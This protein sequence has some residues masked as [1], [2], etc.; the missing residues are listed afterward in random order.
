MIMMILVITSDEGYSHYHYQHCNLTVMIS[1]ILI[2]IVIIIATIIRMLF[3]ITSSCATYNYTTSTGSCNGHSNSIVYI[4]VIINIIIS[5]P[6]TILS[7]YFKKAKRNTLDIYFFKLLT[8]SDC[9]LCL[10]VW[11]IYQCFFFPLM[12]MAVSR[13]IGLSH[14]FLSHHIPF[15][16]T[17]VCLCMSFAS[18]N[19]SLPGSGFSIVCLAGPSTCLCLR[20]S[21]CLSTCGYLLP[22]VLEISSHVFVCSLNI[23]FGNILRIQLCVAY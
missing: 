10:F 21:T 17:F 16:L 2:T 18:A 9:Q 8:K 23:T 19:Y 15:L 3:L 22:G 11:I 5:I 1:I 20:V 6:V 12:C 13:S 7:P 14:F 4:C